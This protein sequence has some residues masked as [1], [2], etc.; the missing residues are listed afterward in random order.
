MKTEAFREFRREVALSVE[1]NQEAIVG[2]RAVCLDPWCLV[3]EFMPYGDLYTYLH[4]MENVIDWKMRIKM[5]LNI[6]EAIRFLHSFQ[7][8]I[9]HRDLKSPNCLVRLLCISLPPKHIVLIISC[10]Y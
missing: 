6:A 5:A 1:L 10:C 8:K 7:P 9:I 2:L 3:M 4:D